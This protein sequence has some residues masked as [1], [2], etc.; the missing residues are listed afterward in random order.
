MENATIIYQTK[1]LFPGNGP[2]LYIFLVFHQNKIKIT[3]EN[4]FSIMS[5]LN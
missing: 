1:L 5:L 4:E 3:T 2:F